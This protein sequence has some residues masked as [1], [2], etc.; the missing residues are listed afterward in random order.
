LA[1]SLRILACS[2]STVLLGSPA[3]FVMATF[4]PANVPADQ[5]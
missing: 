1:F 2:C 5:E 3:L 4:V